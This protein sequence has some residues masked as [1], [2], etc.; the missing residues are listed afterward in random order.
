[1][2]FLIQENVEQSFNSDP[3]SFLLSLLLLSFLL[4][5][6]SFYLHP[7]ILVMFYRQHPHLCLLFFSPF[8]SL[9]PRNPTESSSGSILCEIFLLSLSLSVSLSLYDRILFALR[10]FHAND[11]LQTLILDFSFQTTS[12]SFSSVLFIISFSFSLYFSVLPPSPHF[13]P[14]SLSLVPSSCHNYLFTVLSSR[15][16]ISHRESRAS[17][18]LRCLVPYPGD[19]EISSFESSFS[20]SLSL[21]LSLSLS[22]LPF[23]FVSL[24]PFTFPSSISSHQVHD[25]HYFNPTHNFL[26]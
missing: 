18:S 1:M 3:L 11:M 26:P 4:L 8:H 9:F 16:L 6:H 25:N 5:S 15:D 14:L 21:F 10:V 23:F 22:L 24:K 19:F 12:S 13:L 7:P 20:L 2:T 17:D